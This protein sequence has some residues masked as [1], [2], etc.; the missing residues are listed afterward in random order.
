[1][2]D[3]LTD[4]PT[5]AEATDVLAP[6]PDV[7]APTFASVFAEA[8]DLN[9]K[10]DLLAHAL[11]LMGADSVAQ[12]LKD[13]KDAQ[14]NPAPVIPPA[15]VD[16][17]TVGVGDEVQAPTV[18]DQVG[19]TVPEGSDPAGADLAA[20]LAAEAETRAAADA[21]LGGRVGALEGSTSTTEADPGNATTTPDSSG[22]PAPEPAPAPE[23]GPD[24]LTLP[25]DPSPPT[26]VEPGVI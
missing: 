1:M 11:T 13:R 25:G 21:E 8:R 6:E 24:G 23:P 12:E 18:E 20:Q 22:E 14:Q 3:T 9:E 5:D 16:M 7:V 26:I 4:Q 10:V 19:A 2:S 15:G 17:T